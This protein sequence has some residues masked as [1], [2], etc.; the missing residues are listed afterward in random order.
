MSLRRR[1]SRSTTS[2]R[3]LL[4]DGLLVHKVEVGYPLF[5]SI[6]NNNKTALD[7]VLQ[8]RAEVGTF[9]E[10]PPVPEGVNLQRQQRPTNGRRTDG[11]MFDP[12]Q[13]LHQY[14]YQHQQYYPQF[15]QQQS[16]SA[17]FTNVSSMPSPES[18]A[19]ISPSSVRSSS[20]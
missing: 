1:R 4:G 13:Q 3:I 8:K 17:M 10:P 12:H 6:M 14:Q 2:M 16:T 20:V 19:N 11:S 18:R 7:L 15:T 5:S 9:Q